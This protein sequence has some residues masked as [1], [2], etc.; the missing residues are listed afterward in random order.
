MAANSVLSSTI[1]CFPKRF[2]LNSHKKT[3]H[4]RFILIS[5]P[6]FILISAP[7]FTSYPLRVL[8]SYPFRQSA[9]FR[10]RIRV[11]SLP[12]L[13]HGR[14]SQNMTCFRL[15]FYLYFVLRCTIQWSELKS[16]CLIKVKL[17]MREEDNLFF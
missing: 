2:K 6:R 16:K 12:A 7:R 4:P 11:L 8:S 3:T 5:A 10:I 9:P 14:R 13:I 1:T 17:Y 15:Q